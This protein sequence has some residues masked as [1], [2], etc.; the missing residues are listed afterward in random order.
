MVLDHVNAYA[1]TVR[2]VKRC[3]EFYRDKLGLKLQEMSDDFA[4]PT[5]DKK[6]AWGGSRLRPGLG[7]RDS[8]NQSRPDESLN[9]ATVPCGLP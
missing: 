2:D 8:E 5:F 1:L 9:A 4:Y 6:G 3:A 7:S